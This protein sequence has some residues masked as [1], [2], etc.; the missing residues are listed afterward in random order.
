MTLLRHIDL[1][2]LALALPLFLVAGLPILGYSA[3]AGAWVAQ[4]AIQLAL[5]RRALASRDPKTV[6]GLT[7]GGMIARGWLVALA[8]FGTGIATDD[9]TGLSAALLFIA[10]FTVYFPMNLIVRSLDREEPA[11]DR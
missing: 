6:A 1:A 8:I 3:G 2:L 10:V 11:D 5:E 7:A 4:R 9:A